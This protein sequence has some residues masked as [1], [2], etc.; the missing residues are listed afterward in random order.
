MT[1]QSKAFVS[2]VLLWFFRD[3]GFIPGWIQL[4]PVPS[5]I[6]GMTHDNDSLNVI[7]MTHNL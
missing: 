6:T 2:L 7:I 3:P 1:H 4:F 5:F